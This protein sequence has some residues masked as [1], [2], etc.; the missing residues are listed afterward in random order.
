MGHFGRVPRK[1]VAQE[2]LEIVG[3]DGVTGFVLVQRLDEAASPHAGTVRESAVEVPEN[4][5]RLSRPASH[6]PHH[7]VSRLRF[8]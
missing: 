3:G 6:I 8:N 5:S 2:R 1:P 7:A 4:R